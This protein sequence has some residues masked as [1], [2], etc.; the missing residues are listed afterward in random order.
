MN[1]PLYACL[2]CHHE[3]LEQKLYCSKCLSDNQVEQRIEGRGIVYSHTTIYAAPEKLQALSPYVIVCIDI[4]KGMRLSA[5]CSNTDI[6]I[7][8]TVSI[9]DVTDGAYIAKKEDVTWEH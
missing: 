4:R 1:I 5:R 8:D 7:G 6:K 9:V 2:D 3:W